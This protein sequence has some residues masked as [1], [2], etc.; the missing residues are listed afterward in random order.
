MEFNE[1]QREILYRAWLLARSGNGQVVSDEAV[2][3]AHRLAEAGWLDRYFRDGQLC[4]RWSRAAEH[5]LD[6]NALVRSAD[7][8]EN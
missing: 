2:P 3:D 7:G 4:W 5:A 1:T 8:R 6:V